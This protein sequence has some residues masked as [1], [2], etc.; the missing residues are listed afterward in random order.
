[1]LRHP[2]DSWVGGV[3]QTLPDICVEDLAN[4]GVDEQKIRQYRSDTLWSYEIGAGR[5]CSPMAA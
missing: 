3:Q 2:R 5:A 1:M 4:L